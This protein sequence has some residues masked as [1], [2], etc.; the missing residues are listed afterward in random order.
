[1]EVTI[2]YTR[3][4]GMSIERNKPAQTGEELVSISVGGST[5][6]RTAQQWLDLARRDLRGEAALAK[7]QQSEEAVN[8][9]KLFLYHDNCA[10]DLGQICYI[11]CTE[12][13]RI[14]ARVKEG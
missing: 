13:L 4:I 10:P 9:S 12:L 6:T 8:A 2:I 14:D 7:C 1:M 11:V 3:S 5:H